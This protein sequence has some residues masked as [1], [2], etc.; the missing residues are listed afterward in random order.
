MRAGAVVVLGWLLIGS[1]IRGAE[2]PPD[3][4]LPRPHV[5]EPPLP[6]PVVP[7]PIPYGGYY[8]TSRYAVWQYYA[9]DRRGFERPRVI[10]SPYG[11]YYLY[12]GKRFLYAPIQQRDF[13]PYTT[14]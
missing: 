5:A 8:R 3:E 6:G 1:A 4:T 11:P 13:M 9:T 12:D 7:G 14:D 10:Y 2:R